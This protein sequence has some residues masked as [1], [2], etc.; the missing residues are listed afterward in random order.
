MA[1]LPFQPDSFQSGVPMRLK[2][3]AVLAA[4]TAF[5]AAAQAENCNDTTTTPSYLSCAGSFS[6]NIN[7]DPSETASLAG[8]F[9][10]TWTYGGKSDDANNGPFTSN[11][12]GTAGTLTFDAPVTGTFVIGLKAANNHSYFLFDGGAGGIA[13]IDYDT[14]GV[15]LNK[16]GKP[17]GL[18]H[19]NLYY[20]APPIPEPETYALMLAGLGIVGAIARRRRS[21]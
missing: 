3:L 19:A 11:P 21:A 17:Q 10:G 1:A 12:G 13:S 15:A 7:G 14:L 6:G 5:V 9:G 16:K 2:Q 8:L 4:T 18:S 20:G